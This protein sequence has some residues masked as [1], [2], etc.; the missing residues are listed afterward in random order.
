M[1]EW[2]QN[3]F[4]EIADL[5]PESRARYFAEHAVPDE[6]R[7]HC[8]PSIR[9]LAAIC[10]RA[11]ARRPERAMARLDLND[12]CCG[13]YRLLNRIGHGGMGAVYLAERA[14][15]EVAQRVAIKLLHPGAGDPWRRECFL[16]ERQILAGLS[17]PIS[18]AC[19]TRAT[20]TTD[21]RFSSWS[22]SMTTRS[23]C[24]RPIS[25]SAPFCFVSESM[26]GCFVFASQSGCAPGFEAQ[27]HPGNG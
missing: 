14:D 15:G 4:H 26:C 18:R 5:T 13:A 2:V 9:A 11:S 25:A 20:A 1:N 6:T 17:H 27:R 23:M 21:S 22:T 8:W 3:L 7:K 10:N 24:S 12:Q 16:Q 19:S